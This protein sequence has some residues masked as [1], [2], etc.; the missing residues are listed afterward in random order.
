MEHSEQS[1][2]QLKA[3]QATLQHTTETQGSLTRSHIT[4]EAEQ[5]REILAGDDNNNKDLLQ[6]VCDALS[7]AEMDARREEV[8]QPHKDTFQWIYTEDEDHLKWDNF[9]RWLRQGEELYWMNG[10]P[11][12]GKSTLMRYV[13]EDTRTRKTLQEWSGVSVTVLSFFFWK[14]ASE[15]LQKNI[16]GLRRAL[17][18][19]LL[20]QLP[21][22]INIAASF[23]G[24]SSGVFGSPITLSDSRVS[25]CF[26][27]VLEN[28]ATTEGQHF[29]IFVDGLDEAEEACQD[30]IVTLIQD[31]ARIDRVKLCVSSRPEER[32]N[33]A[34]RRCP[35]YVPRRS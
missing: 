20:I 1:L 30:V 10:K 22:S 33:Q 29:C 12:S 24:L 17:L 16:A 35:G 5:L 23:L 9:K 21:D 6:A 8:N 31:L 34:F 28:L 27:L 4:A 2:D 11:G 18:H 3:G 19:Q 25:T 15:A 7:F 32:F 26:R 14:P 13:L